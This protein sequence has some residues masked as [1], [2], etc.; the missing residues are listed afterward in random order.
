MAINRSTTTAHMTRKFFIQSAAMTTAGAAVGAAGVL[1][2]RRVVVARPI[3]G[4]TYREG[5]RRACATKR[6]TSVAQA[7]RFF[8]GVNVPYEL[9]IDA[10]RRAGAHR[11]TL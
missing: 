2:A 4:H 5:F 10:P 11:G 8:R 7:S 9:L 6:F 1:A 3:A